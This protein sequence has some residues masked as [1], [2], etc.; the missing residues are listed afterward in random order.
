MEI[1]I[2]GN[3]GGEEV[4]DKFYGS[5]K[6]I[7]G[8]FTSSVGWN[9]VGAWSISGGLA[10]NAGGA[11]NLYRNVS[12]VVGDIYI[13]VFEIVEYTSGAIHF[14]LAGIMGISR[15]GVGVYSQVLRSVSTVADPYLYFTS[16]GSLF[17]GK[18]DNVSIRKVISGE[19]GSSSAGGEI[20]L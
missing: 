10:I 20:L 11:S 1:G 6:V 13:V 4:G 19:M 17:I 3:Y 15:S 2:F 12:P 9:V 14:T 8:N 7:N 5:E 18:I 16:E